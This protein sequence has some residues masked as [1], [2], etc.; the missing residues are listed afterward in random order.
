MRCHP[1]PAAHALGMAVEVSKLRRIGAIDPVGCKAMRSARVWGA[2]WA[3]RDAGEQPGM[4]KMMA[5]ARELLERSAFRAT[6]PLIRE[7]F[8]MDKVQNGLGAAKNWVSAT[9][10]LVADAFSEGPGAGAASFKVPRRCAWSVPSSPS[11]SQI[12]DDLANSEFVKETERRGR[13]F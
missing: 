7:A 9:E 12:G 13:S 2:C 3:V 6:A 11:R 5:E 8:P 1:P 4:Q 10:M